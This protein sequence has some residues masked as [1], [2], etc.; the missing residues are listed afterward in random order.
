MS[1]IENGRFVIPLYHGTSSLF[2]DSISQYGLGAVNVV[3]K[4]N[5]VPFLREAYDLADEVLEGDEYWESEGSLIHQMALQSNENF[6]FQHGHAYLTAFYTNA[7]SYV[8]RNRLGSEIISQ[9]EKLY[10][11]LY[12]RFAECPGVE[13]DSLISL[14]GKEANPVVLEIRDVSVGEVEGERGDDPDIV[15][16]KLDAL[17]EAGFD[18]AEMEIGSLGLRLVRP[19]SSDRIEVLPVLPS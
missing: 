6:N 1:I 17:H 10:S 18:F 11:K 15:I 5:V 14:F 3:E 16:Q 8:K 12:P 9:A 7:S 13:S 2:L 4:H 19:V